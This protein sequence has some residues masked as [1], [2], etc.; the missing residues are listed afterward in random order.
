MM[1]NTQ[2]QPILVAARVRKSEFIGPGC[3]VQ[4]AGVV[5]GIA[6]WYFAGMQ[7]AI[8]GGVAGLVLLLIG[9]RLALKWRCGACN[10]VTTGDARMCATCKAELR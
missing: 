10:N 4:G 6:A 1:R 8:V 5:I 7:G 2:G 9:G 3:I